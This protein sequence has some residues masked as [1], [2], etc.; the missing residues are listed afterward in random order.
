MATFQQLKGQYF[1]NKSLH[2][3]TYVKIRKAYGDDFDFDDFAQTPL[4]FGLM[5]QVPEIKNQFNYAIK[6]HD[7][8]YDYF[9]SEHVTEML[10]S[11]LN[12]SD[13][14]RAFFRLNLFEYWGDCGLMLDPNSYRCWQTFMQVLYDWQLDVDDNVDDDLNRKLER[15]PSS[16]PDLIAIANQGADYMA[17]IAKTVEWNN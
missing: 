17:K 5:V 14:S 15:I 6:N 9:T 10:E 11:A 2:S 1:K 8:N 4:F 3:K 16:D 12:Y 7:F 13:E